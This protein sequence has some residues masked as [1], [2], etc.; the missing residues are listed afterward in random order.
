MRLPCVHRWWPLNVSDGHA[1]R[2]TVPE[3][4]YRELRHP[5]VAFGRAGA[6]TVMPCPRQTVNV[7][8]MTMRRHHWPSSI[9]LVT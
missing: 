2:V 5:R 7:V 3:E 4:P 6:H 1:L 9:P 8:T